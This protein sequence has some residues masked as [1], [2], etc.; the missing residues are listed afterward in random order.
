VA[1]ETSPASPPHSS[2]SGKGKHGEGALGAGG[3]PAK[4]PVGRAVGKTT[5]L[6]GH[7]TR[8]RPHLWDGRHWARWAVGCSAIVHDDLHRAWRPL[9]VAAGILHAALE[10]VVA[11]CRHP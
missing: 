2:L 7:S 5:R 6:G 4:W 8:C 3:L 9:P 11:D 10:P 1:P